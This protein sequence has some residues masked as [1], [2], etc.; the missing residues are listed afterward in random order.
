MRHSPSGNPLSKV[1]FEALTPRHRV[2]VSLLIISLS[3]TNSLARAL[4]RESGK[5]YL[6][7]GKG[8]VHPAASLEQELRDSLW[9]METLG[10]PSGQGGILGVA[11]R[12][13]E[14][15]IIWRREGSV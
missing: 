12:D 2:T 4:S 6:R 15:G 5:H 14:C 13:S 10:R 8:R 3:H 9:A 11:A 1:A 7:H